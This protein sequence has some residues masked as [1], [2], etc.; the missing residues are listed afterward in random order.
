[1]KLRTK[2]DSLK[3]NDKWILIFV[4][5]LSALLTVH[6]GNDNSFQEL[7]QIPSYYTDLLLAFTCALL[8][9][10]YYRILFKKIDDRFNWTDQLKK[11]IAYHLLYGIFFPV[12]IAIII[13][14]IY[15]T[16]LLDIPLNDSSIFYLELPVIFIFCT[17]INLIYI[18]LYFQKHNLMLSRAL[19]LQQETVINTRDGFKENFVV[20]NGVR[21]LN[22]PAEEIAYFQVVEKSTFLVTNQGQKHLYDSSLEYLIQS[23]DQKK[24]FQLNRQMVASRSSIK[25]YSPTHTRKLSVT[26]VP[27]ITEDVYVSKSKA[28]AFLQWLKEH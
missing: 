23:V 15:L 10:F 8:L 1:M 9:A 20:N 24:F 18:L 16:I 19:I 13:E 17:L 22:I 4:Y 14:S 11:R 12:T 7:L 21:S 3:V 28:S 27:E 2:E 6:I 25:T 5:P 26:L